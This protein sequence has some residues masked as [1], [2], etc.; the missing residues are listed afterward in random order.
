MRQMSEPWKNKG[1][2]LETSLMCQLIISDRFYYIIKRAKKL[3]WHLRTLTDSSYEQSSTPLAPSR[4][5]PHGGGS[6]SAPRKCNTPFHGRIDIFLFYTCSWW[7]DVGGALEPHEQTD[8]S[9]DTCSSPSGG[10]FGTVRSSIWHCSSRGLDFILQYLGHG[11]VGAVIE[12]TW[13]TLVQSCKY[14]IST[15]VSNLHK[16]TP[17]RILKCFLRCD[18]TKPCVDFKSN[19]GGKILYLRQ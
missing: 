6:C 19:M 2:I 12:S 14:I 11:R 9:P 5:F 17:N 13:V 4:H 15:L 3:P 18:L 1:S 16:L 10:S 8:T 7:I